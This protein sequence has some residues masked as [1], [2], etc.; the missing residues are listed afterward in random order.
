MNTALRLLWIL[1]GS[2]T[3]AACGGGHDDNMPAPAPAM[4]PAR[5]SLIQSPPARTASLTPDAIAGALTNQPGANLLLD[6]IV[7]PKCASTFTTSVPHRGPTLRRPVRGDDDSYRQRSAARAR[8]RSS[9]YRARHGCAALAQPREHHDR[10]QS[11]RPARRDS[12]HHA[13]IHPRRTELHRLRH[14]DAVVQPVSQCRS[15]SEGHDR[16]SDGRAQRAADELRADGGRFRQVVR[17]R[18]LAGRT[19][20]DGDSQDAPGN[21]RRDHGVGADVRSVCSRCV[22]R[23]SVLRRGHARD[24]V[25]LR[26]HCHRLQKA[27]GDVYRARRILRSAPCHRHRIVAPASVPHAALQTASCRAINCSTAAA[28]SELRTVHAGRLNLAAVA[29]GTSFGPI[30]W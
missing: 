29:P 13:G 22:L 2:L 19:R 14:V 16:C 3:L 24:A 17:Y 21:R 4:P 10:R 20:R 9:L 5:G 18:L 12:F 8:I 28:R 6:L 1:G 26:V 25:V 27:Y 23:C 30:I 15:G 7:A 11:R